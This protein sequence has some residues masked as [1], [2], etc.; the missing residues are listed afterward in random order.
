MLHAAR[1]SSTRNL[2]AR[3]SS[4]GPLNMQE[5]IVEGRLSERHV[6]VIAAIFFAVIL[7]VNGVFL[8][9]A[10]TSPAKEVSG[11]SQASAH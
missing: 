11:A 5:F 8:Y 7:A 9:Q 6:F 3:V 2:S 10:L 1:L 4:M